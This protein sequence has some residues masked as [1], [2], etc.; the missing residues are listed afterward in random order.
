ME[1]EKKNSV[2]CSI[3]AKQK[4]SDTVAV[5]KSETPRMAQSYPLHSAV[6][7]QGAKILI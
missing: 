3:R 2:T 5:G 1:K 6:A 4:R 7:V